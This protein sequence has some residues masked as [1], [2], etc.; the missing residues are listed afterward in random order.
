MNRILLTIGHKKNLIDF[1]ECVIS[2]H[3]WALQ[4]NVP[5]EI[6]ELDENKNESWQF[7]E[8]F[9]Y[10]HLKNTDKTVIAA[11]PSVMI[12]DKF[13]QLFD[14]KQGVVSNIGETCFLIG[15]HDGNELAQKLLI[16]SLA[17]REIE[18]IECNLALEV[19]SMKSNFIYFIDKFITKP[20][21]PRLIQ[22]LDKNRVGFEIHANTA[23]NSNF[24]LSYNKIESG[25]IYE[26]GEFGVNLNL[27]NLDLSKGFISEFKQ[28]KDKILETRELM[29]EMHQDLK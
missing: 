14:I 18:N 1:E 6:I 24:K 20:S 8:A 2:Q 16:K 13:N 27:N 22:D 21:Y 17:F 3:E 15:K 26:G 11:L 4:H 19:L 28:I 5:H 23:K 12:L 10:Y 7:Y 29:Q 9:I 25:Q